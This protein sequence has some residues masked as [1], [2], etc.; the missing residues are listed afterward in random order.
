MTCRESGEVGVGGE[1]VR[2]E[3]VPGKGEGIWEIVFRD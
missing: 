3:I 1:I 2:E